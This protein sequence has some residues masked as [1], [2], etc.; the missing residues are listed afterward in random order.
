[1]KKQI[2]FLSENFWKLAYFL[3]IFLTANL[4]FADS[5]N[6][7]VENY[8]WEKVV[9][10]NSLKWD[11]KC[12]DNWDMSSSATSWV[13]SKSSDWVLFVFSSF[14]EVFIWNQCFQ[15]DIKKFDKLYKFS[16]KKWYDLSLNCSKM[17]EIDKI[18]DEIKFEKSQFISWA[19]YWDEDLYWNE[20]K[21]CKS[22]MPW[23]I[24]KT[25][26]L[27]KK[28]QSIWSDSWKITDISFDA[29]R[30][31]SNAK[32]N[33]RKRFEW[34]INKYLKSFWLTSNFDEK[35][36]YFSNFSLEK[37][38]NYLKKLS[39][40]IWN[41]LSKTAWFFT[42][43]DWEGGEKKVEKPVLNLSEWND[44]EKIITKKNNQ[45]NEKKVI[46]FN[47]ENFSKEPLFFKVDL[48]ITNNII[49][50]LW[51]LESNIILAEWTIKDMKEV[52]KYDAKNDL[53]LRKFI[54][55]MRIFLDKHNT[56]VELPRSIFIKNDYN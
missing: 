55:E 40:N 48:E 15:R 3:I 39:I 46:D 4:T 29:E 51:I 7:E 11:W 45:N 31:E 34:N 54:K 24:K 1:M 50:T 5:P 18:I 9:E 25:K 53:S 44:I 33:A 10:I 14:T 21:N 41:I 30:A 32:K 38:T 28:I 23:I 27:W 6:E 2:I 8:L 26:D 12:W 17:N 49:D 37:S 35:D 36:S 20:P 56:K 43:S 22:A 52:W 19:K 47:L 42:I 13:A 16:L